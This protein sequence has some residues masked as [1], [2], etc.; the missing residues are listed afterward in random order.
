MPGVGIRQ[1]KHP[2]Q[3]LLGTSLGNGLMNF[4][5][6]PQMLPLYGKHFDPPSKLDS[7]TTSI[8]LG[9]DTSGSVTVASLVPTIGYTVPQSVTCWAAVYLP[10]T[11]QK[12]TFVGLDEYPTADRGLHLGV[13]SGTF[14]TLGNELIFLH[15]SVF[16]VV[17]GV[18]IGTGVH[19]VAAVNTSGDGAVFYL[20]GKEVHSDL[21]ARATLLTGRAVMGTI[22]SNTMARKLSAGSVVHSAI[23]RRRLADQE[24]MRLHRMTMQGLGI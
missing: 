21:T 9:P 12:G 18:S 2:G 13:G 16:W 15:G 19:T 17:S 6:G 1:Y 5:S 7:F 11:S 22:A 3:R 8:G 10:T 4:V 23:W 14:D 20:D 24:F